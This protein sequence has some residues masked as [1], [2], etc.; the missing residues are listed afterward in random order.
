MA[1]VDITV[2]DNISAGV[3]QKLR[4]ISNAARTASKNVDL[5]RK[6]LGE[7]GTLSNV[8]NNATSSAS[9]LTA[10][11][12]KSNSAVGGLRGNVTQLNTA[13]NGN[14]RAAAAMARGLAQAGNQAQ[15]T[16]TQ[17]RGLSTSTQ[18]L[19]GLFVAGF[20]VRAFIEAADAATTVS[21]KVRTVS[22]DLQIYK[23][24]LDAVYA[25]AINNRVAVESVATA[26]QRFS[27]AMKGTPANEVISLIDTLTKALIVNG[28]TTE[29]TASVVTQLSQAFTKGK[30]DGDEFRSL[31]ENLPGLGDALSKSLGASRTELFDLSK[32]GK[33]TAEV[34]AEA[35][36]G[37]KAQIDTAFAGTIPTIGQA[38]A[39]LRNQF[40]LF[41]SQNTGAAVLLANAIIAIGNNLNIVIPIIVAFGTAW[42]VVQL[43]NIVRDVLALTAAFIAF[44]PQVIAVT[45]AML[46]WIAGFVAAAAAILAV[47]ELIAFLT[48]T[49]ED[50]HKWIKDTVGTIG[51][52]VKGL[53]GVGTEGTQAF[54]SLAQGGAETSQQLKQATSD[55]QALTAAASDAGSTTVTAFNNA[56]SAVSSLNSEVKSLSQNLNYSA[57]Q[58]TKL[59]NALKK[60]DYNPGN[61]DPSLINTGSDSSF[62]PLGKPGT[63]DGGT[64]AYANG[65]SFMV[66]G[67]SGVDK[68]RV[69]FRASKGERVDVLTPQQQRDQARALSGRTGGPMARNVYITIN[70]PN[71]DSFARSRRQTAQ[72]AASMVGA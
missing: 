6:S 60:G 13:L 44:L 9:K 2:S 17:V 52:F 66:G 47:A 70:T 57:K 59:Y 21:N 48:G 61:Y 37:M 46:P 10:Q 39:V 72:I 23:Q 4:G 67:R 20:G 51:D 24:N 29:E 56:K 45:V 11:I 14:A 58:A 1:D 41:M 55:T 69:A 22:A 68:N 42:A 12:N 63:P 43:V 53:V 26:F 16:S 30:L 32:Q 31:M 34:I 28:A 18:Q 19:V 62:Q 36:K 3:E 40:I 50:F 49:T 25:V 7:F 65:G 35:F 33:I 71:A 54:G 15:R 38:L 64:P 8:F 27:V 5:L